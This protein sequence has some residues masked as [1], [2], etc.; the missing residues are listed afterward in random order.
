MRHP[1]TLIEF[2]QMYA[3][4]EDCRRALF[5]HRWPQ[6]FSCPRCGHEQA[7]HLR[8]RDLYECASCH[9]QGSLT[10]GTV[11]ARTRTDLRKWLLAIWLLVR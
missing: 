7:W 5:E 9:Y 8:G 6:G 10:A 1:R 4:E 2:M 3:T 11:F